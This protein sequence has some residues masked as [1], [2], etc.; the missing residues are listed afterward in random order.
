LLAS[1]DLLILQ[2]DESMAPCFFDA[3]RSGNLGG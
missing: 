3:V 2:K 1:V